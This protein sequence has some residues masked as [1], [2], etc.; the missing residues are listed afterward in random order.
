[1]QMHYTHYD[2]RCRL[3]QSWMYVQVLGKVMYR[4]WNISVR[5]DA[6]EICETHC[7]QIL[8]VCSSLS[9]SAVATGTKLVASEQE[10]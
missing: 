2:E 5:S 7:L 6:I 1:M 3:S 9:E 4:C 8:I 10:T